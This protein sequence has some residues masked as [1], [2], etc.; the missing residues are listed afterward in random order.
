MT[1]R[2]DVA[3]Y[4]GSMAAELA[5]LARTADGLTEV[6]AKLE[7]VAAEANRRRSPVVSENKV[8]SF[9]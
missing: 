8:A 2:S 4:I 5:K 7:Q 1:T 3:E 9:Q 6:A